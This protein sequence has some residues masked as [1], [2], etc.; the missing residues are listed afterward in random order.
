[1]S[2][3]KTNRT[4]ADGAELQHEKKENL[5]IVFWVCFFC[6]DY[7]GNKKTRPRWKKERCLFCGEDWR[8]NKKPQCCCADS[9]F[10]TSAHKPKLKRKIVYLVI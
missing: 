3:P 2:P 9:L 5:T 6:T 7:H 1:M 4:R 10:L 8:L